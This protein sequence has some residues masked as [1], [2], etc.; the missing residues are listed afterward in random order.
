MAGMIGSVINPTGHRY[1]GLLGELQIFF[2]II[3]IHY[4]VS[5][6]SQI[7][8]RCLQDEMLWHEL[9][10]DVASEARGDI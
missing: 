7:G 3:M 1:L 10:T 4:F 5:C 9:E 2:I 6:D 8:W